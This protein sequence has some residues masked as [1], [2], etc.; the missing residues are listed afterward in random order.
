MRARDF[1]V[2]KV[3]REM[4]GVTFMLRF[5]AVGPCYRGDRKQ[6]SC[7]GRPQLRGRGFS[8]WRKIL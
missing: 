6:S 5:E 2:T 3:S 1:R 7:C 8:W 4:G